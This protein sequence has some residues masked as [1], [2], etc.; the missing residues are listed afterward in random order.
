MSVYKIAGKKFDMS[1]SHRQPDLMESS[2]E[3]N[4]WYYNA[5]EGQPS[6]AGES[7]T[8][9][10]AEGKQ[11]PY[12]LG[13]HSLKSMRSLLT[14]SGFVC[15]KMLEIGFNLGY[16]AR[17]W[18]SLLPEVQLTSVDISNKKE[19]LTAAAVVSEKYPDRFRFVN[20]DS[21]TI[22]SLLPG[23]TFDIAFIDGDHSEEGIVADIQNC[24]D[25]GIKTMLFDDWLPEFGLTIPALSRFKVREIFVNGNLALARF[26]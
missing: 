2:Q 8:G 9:F 4:T 21:K 16:S 23:E 10:D 18:L 15:G 11:I 14:E 1:K 17:I 22:A 12:S 5:V 13:P 7:G 6:H 20:A 26:S 24:L 3:D 25:L 19:T